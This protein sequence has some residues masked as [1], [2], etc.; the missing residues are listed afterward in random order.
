[1]RIYAF[2]PPPHG[3]PSDICIPTDSN[4][5]EKIPEDTVEILRKNH[6]LRLSCS[7]N[8]AIVRTER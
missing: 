7:E 1:V 5:E 6:D 4:A 2:P 3:L 8:E